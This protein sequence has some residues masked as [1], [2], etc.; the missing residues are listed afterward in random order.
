MIY[1]VYTVIWKEWKELFRLRGSLKGGTLGVLIFLCVFGIFL[2]LQMGRQ[3]VEIPALLMLW[4]WVPL[5]LVTSVIADAFA[6]ERERNTLET[7]LASRLSDTSI[8]FGKIAAAVGY[9]WGL[10]LISL[11]L[12]TLSINVAEAS[13]EFL[14]FSPVM[15]AGIFLWSFLGASLT[16]CVGVLI[17]LKASTVRQ[18]QQVLSIA[19]MMLL[20]IPM[21][22]FKALPESWRLW[23]E[24]KVSAFTME[25]TVYFVT[26]VLA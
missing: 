4:I 12:G 22:G 10:T 2:P 8:L 17:S 3:W 13:G 21:F 25:E 6:G 23:I 14:F 7:L 15:C 16:A 24:S 1:D 20:I 9:G 5:F 18:A 26:A 11:L 19:I